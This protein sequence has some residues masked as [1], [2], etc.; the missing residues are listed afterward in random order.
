MPG[1]LPMVEVAGI[2]ARYRLARD[3]KRA[4]LALIGPFHRTVAS[5][6]KLAAR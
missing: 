3:L 6:N 1:R 2:T 4:M 5:V